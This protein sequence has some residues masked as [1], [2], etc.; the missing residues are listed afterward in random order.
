MNKASAFALLCAFPLVAQITGRLSGKVEDATGAAIP[1]ASIEL[2]LPDNK[3]AVYNSQTSA[4]GYFNFI[5]LRAGR[6]DLSVQAPG[7]QSY[8]AKHIDIDPGRELTLATIKMK[9]GA[10]AETINVVAQAVGVQTANAEISTTVTIDRIRNLPVLDQQV[11]ALI[12]TQAGVSILRGPTTINGLRT[13][14]PDRPSLDQVAEFTIITSNA[15]TLGG[16]VLVDD[17]DYSF[18]E[19]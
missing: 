12:Q 3:A 2:F 6:Y 7:F 1:G 17:H 14:L 18:G 8:L 15:N 11:I 4:E 9:V 10:V 16:G 19:Q 5:G 13:F